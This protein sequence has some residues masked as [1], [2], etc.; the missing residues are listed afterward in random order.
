M[1]ITSIA[2]GATLLLSAFLLTA[3]ES[4]GAFTPDSCDAAARTGVDGS[5]VAAVYFNKTGDPVGA[6]E[7][8]G[9]KDNKMCPTP[10]EGGSGNCPAG[11]CSRTYGGTSYC[12]RC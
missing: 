5:A 7:L 2:R 9:T 3:C 10:P 4:R 6:E 8:K 12:M 11:Y 1:N